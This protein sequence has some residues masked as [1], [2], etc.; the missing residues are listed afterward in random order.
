[1]NCDNTAR[2]GDQSNNGAVEELAGRM[3][4]LLPFERLSVC[5]QSNLMKTYMKKVG[6]RMKRHPARQ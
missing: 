6:V 5:G 4:T 2:E 1:M 3:L